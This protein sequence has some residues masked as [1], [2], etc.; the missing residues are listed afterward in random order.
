MGITTSISFRSD[1]FCT[2]ILFNL[3]I[4]SRNGTYLVFSTLAAASHYTCFWWTCMGDVIFSVSP[5]STHISPD[6]NRL[7]VRCPLLCYFAHH[8][9]KETEQ[10]YFMVD[11]QTVFR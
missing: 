5:Y 4:Y 3:S 10:F 8:L 1:A 2:N 6:G 9:A 7:M 11:V